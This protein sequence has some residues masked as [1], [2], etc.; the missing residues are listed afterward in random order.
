MKQI[1]SEEKYN[2]IS[3][4]DKNFI[5]AFDEEMKKIGYE[6]TGIMPYAC[7]GKYMTGYTKS[8]IKT[9]KYVARFYY[10]EDG[11]I[12]RMYFSQTDK[13]REYIENAP[14]YIQ[15][16]FIND[17]GICQHCNNNCKDEYGNC[18]HRKTYTLHGITYEKCDGQVFYFEHHDTSMISEYIGLIREFYP[19]RRK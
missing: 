17:I 13:R 12:F 9:K 10:R 2:F 19:V 15:C 18:S 7:W 3:D 8:G 11:I 5:L 4:N 6:S 14:D 1:L 16:A